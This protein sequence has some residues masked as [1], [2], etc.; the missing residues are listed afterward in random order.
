MLIHVKPWTE[1]SASKECRPPRRTSPLVI[2]IAAGPRIRP[3][4][5]ATSNSS[6]PEYERKNPATRWL[7]TSTSWLGPNKGPKAV[8]CKSAT[9][10]MLRSAICGRDLKMRE[11]G[12]G[13]LFLLAAMIFASQSLAQRGEKES[14]LDSRRTS[15]SQQSEPASPRIGPISPLFENK[16]FCTYRGGPKTGI[17]SCQ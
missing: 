10:R 16:R 14:Q 5:W 6:G 1:I 12:L 11:H 9:A 3:I 2:I 8:L 13:Y 15:V 4:T 7:D 17:W